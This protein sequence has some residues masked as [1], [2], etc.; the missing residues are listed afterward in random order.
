M[1]DNEQPTLKLSNDGATERTPAIRTIVQPHS[2]IC[3]P[4]PSN[5]TCTNGSAWIGKQ[6]VPHD[7]A[8]SSDIRGDYSIAATLR[9]E[10]H[11]SGRPWPDGIASSSDEH[12]PCCDSYSNLPSRD[13]TLA[14]PLH[15]S[16][17]AQQQLMAVLLPR[18]AARKLQLLQLLLLLLYQH[19]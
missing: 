16:I 1:F 10:E 9:S 13:I 2:H 14:A 15:S 3:S 8:T 12:G 6:R 5:P 11:H 4:A 7:A 17:Q 18:I 19:H